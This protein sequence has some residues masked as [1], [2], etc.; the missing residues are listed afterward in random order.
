MPAQFGEPFPQALSRGGSSIAFTMGVGAGE[1]RLDPTQ[2]IEELRS[3]VM[4][5]PL[6]A[7]PSGESP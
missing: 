2:L 6:P 3:S 4:G 7:L 1:E 5:L